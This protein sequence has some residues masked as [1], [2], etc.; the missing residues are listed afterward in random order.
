[1]RSPQSL[2]KLEQLGR[3]RLSKSFFMP[4]FLYSEISNFYGIPNIPENPDLAIANGK[5]LCELLL[6][7]LQDTFGRIAIRSAY[8]SA[9]VNAYGN[10]KGHNCASNE[11]NFAGHIW[12]IPNKNGHGATACIVI[13]W[14]TDKYKA[15]RDWRAMAYWI[16]NHL[17]YSS[18]Q[19]FPKLCAFNLNW[20]ENPERSIHSY[21]EPK[22]YLLRGEPQ[23][24]EYEK[25]DEGF[26]A[27]KL[28]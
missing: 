15:G 11:S 16:H 13:P 14:F 8:R 7:P 2:D 25:Y 3:V 4:D 18:M 10:D 6:E 24:P 1:M 12:D 9:K 27:L 26:P 17:P 5:E 28:K 22:G 19:F 23:N 20:H 21:I